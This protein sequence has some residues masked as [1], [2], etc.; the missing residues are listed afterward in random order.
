MDMPKI[1]CVSCDS[2]A[3]VDENWVNTVIKSDN[4]SEFFCLKCD[5]RWKVK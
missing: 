2:G 5:R 3:S 4:G 1:V